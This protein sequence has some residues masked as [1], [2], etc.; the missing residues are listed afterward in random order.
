MK[1]ARRDL[2]GKPTIG[3]VNRVESVG[4]GK[5]KVETA[6]GYKEDSK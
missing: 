6:R 3:N 4:L 5:L 2:L 1:Y